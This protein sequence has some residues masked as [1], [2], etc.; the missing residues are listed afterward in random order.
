MTHT[1]QPFNSLRIQRIKSIRSR[2]PSVSSRRGWR[3]PF[4][5][6]L[7]LCLAAMA[8]GY[9]LLRYYLTPPQALLVLGGEPK[10]EQFAAKFAQT[11]PDLPIWV[12]SGSPKEYA[13]WVFEKAG[14]APRRIHLDYQAVDT[15]TN[16][17]T[18][19][20]QLK[21]HQIRSVYLIT[22]DDHMQRAR[23]V[24]EII[25]GSNGIDLRPV[26]FA[27]GRQPEPTGKMVRDVARSLL[28]LTTGDTGSSWL[29]SL[30]LRTPKS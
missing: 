19:V 11:H 14:I 10:R 13:N 22:S 18:L 6:S 21:Q 15:V 1:V 16:F 5:L 20:H 3:L 2:Q 30:Q 24:G 23:W 7:V 27:S 4:W 12:S 29:Q 28:W 25:L 9:K 26:P 8:G 17:T